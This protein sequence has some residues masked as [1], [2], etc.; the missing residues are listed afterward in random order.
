[1]RG[2]RTSTHRRLCLDSNS[3]ARII[4]AF[5]IHAFPELCLDSNSEARI[6]D[7][8]GAV[9]AVELCLDS[10]SEARIMTFLSIVR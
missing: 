6:I 10:N 1:M 8:V 2:K 7:E 5:M 3:E 9:A 4:S